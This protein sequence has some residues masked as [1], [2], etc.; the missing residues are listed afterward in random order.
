ML[1]AIVVPVFGAKDSSSPNY[2]QQGRPWRQVAKLDPSKRASALILQVGS[3]A[4]QVCVSAGN[5]IISNND[6]PNQISGISREHFAPAAAD[7][8]FQEVVRL[9][10][11]K[12]TDQ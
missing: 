4:R 8:G 9:L 1:P 2:E 12:K 10:R 7:A 6:G 5:D 11:L 3:A